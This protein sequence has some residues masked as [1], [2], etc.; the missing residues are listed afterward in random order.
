M[1]ERGH[2]RERLVVDRETGVVTH[3]VTP[4]LPDAGFG[5]RVAGLKLSVAEAGPPEVAVLRLQCNGCGLVTDL[6]YGRPEYPGG[7]IEGDDGDFCP[8]CVAQ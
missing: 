6:D 7:W 3:T 2:Q 1:A 5:D 8:A 4:W